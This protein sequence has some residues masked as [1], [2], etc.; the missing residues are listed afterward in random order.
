MSLI[1]RRRWLAGFI[2]GLGPASASTAQDVPPAL[3]PIDPTGRPPGPAGPP[4]YPL[5]RPRP[6]VVE[7]PPGG[8]L[9]GWRPIPIDPVALEKVH[10][11]KHVPLKT[12][13][14]GWRRLQGRIFGYPEEFEP[15][16]L[17]SALYEANK[18]MTANAAEAGL[19]LHR[20]DFLEGSAE[21][22][23]R[24]GDQLAKVAAQLAVCPFPL[25]V[26]RT[27]DDPALAEARRFAVLARLA[28]GP[29]P[30]PSERVVVGVPRAHGL[31]GPD[32][33]VIAGNA[34]GRTQQYGPP[35]PINSNGVNSPSGVTSSS[36]S[37]NIN[38]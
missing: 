2:L 9:P 21:L 14:W 5:V 11:P 37:S 18:I 28:R 13:S 3:P 34:L 30:V 12:R 26:E 15:R 6:P 17:G 4:G 33:Q 16:P 27:P 35:I 1:R 7:V 19:I 24:G 38:P 10:P 29:S 23:P 8:N 25:I 36:S 31:S 22:S 32:A 20:F